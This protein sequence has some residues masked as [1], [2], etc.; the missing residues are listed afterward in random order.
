MSQ[1]Y[2]FSY[3]PQHRSRAPQPRER[4]TKKSLS[5]DLVI[6]PPTEYTSCATQLVRIKTSKSRG[7][8]RAYLTKQNTDTMAGDKQTRVVV[9][10]KMRG[11]H[12]KNTRARL[13]EDMDLDDARVVNEEW[14][15]DP[16]CCE[17]CYDFVMNAN[18]DNLENIEYLREVFPDVKDLAKK[19]VYFGE[20][21][22]DEDLKAMGLLY[23]SE[24]AEKVMQVLNETALYTSLVLPRATVYESDSESDSELDELWEIVG[25]KRQPVEEGSEWDVMSEF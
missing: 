1:H 12:L 3:N 14:G 15:R 17:Q 16:W 11:R 13:E 18:N 23:D 6:K 25:G 9:G 10:R 22:S 4:A 21:A 5:P 24:E 19:E 20:E 2:N 7:L 8:N